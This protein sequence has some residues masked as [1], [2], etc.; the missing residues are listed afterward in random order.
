[1]IT[2]QAWIRFNQSTWYIRLCKKACCAIND[3]THPQPGWHR[4]RT[5]HRLSLELHKLCT[6]LNLLT[7][8]TLPSIG[9]WASSRYMMTTMMMVRKRWTVTYVRVRSF[10][11]SWTLKRDQ[12][13]ASLVN[14][15]HANYRHTSHSAIQ[16]SRSSTHIHV[17]VCSLPEQLDPNVRLLVAEQLQWDQD[18]QI[19][20]SVSYKLWYGA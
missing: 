13:V 8:W 15:E 19:R 14:H 9:P 6:D 10:V 12:F 2:L 20:P 3:D 17:S 18:G 5:R 11:D 1:M 7:L 16:C 4:M